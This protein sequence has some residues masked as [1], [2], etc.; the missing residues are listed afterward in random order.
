MKRKE[1]KPHE[2]L[3]VAAAGGMII[4]FDD[5]SGIAVSVT[6]LSHPSRKKRGR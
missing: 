2:I 6:F 1:K 3:R 4:A 5:V